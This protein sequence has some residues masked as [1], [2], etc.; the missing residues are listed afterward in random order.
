MAWKDKLNKKINFK[1]IKNSSKEKN[2][3][4]KEVLQ[5]IVN[6][7]NVNNSFKSITYILIMAI[8]FLLFL[9][10]YSMG[11]SISQ[12]IINTKGGVAT[13]IFEVI[14]NPKVSITDNNKEGTYIF[15]VRN[16]DSKGKISE[17]KTKYVVEIQD[18][19]DK[20][21]KNTI[22]L[23]LYK[24]GQKVDLQNQ[25]TEKMDL[26]NKVKQ[27]DKYELKISY[28]REFS[29]FMQDIMEKIQVQVHSEQEA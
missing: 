17:V 26:V 1:L 7:K 5:E 11:K 14:S 19:I 2:N 29:S 12:T 25:I 3:T 15:Y 4:E 18:T 8:I 23:E 9:T 20:N 24:N 27:E 10:G 22:K 16:Y 13:P 6:V 21:L 28:N